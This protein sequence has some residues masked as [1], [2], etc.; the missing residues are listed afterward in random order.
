[1]PII[2]PYRI[3]SKDEA[4]DYLNALLAKPEYRTW[5]EVLR[6][7]QKYISNAQIRVY[8]IKKGKEML[9]G[10]GIDASCL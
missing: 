9:K 6:R 4:D 3:D 8:F 5:H 7:A 2:E 1:M 10:Y